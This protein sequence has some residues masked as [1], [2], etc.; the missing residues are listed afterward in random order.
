[1]LTHYFS[2]DK[3]NTKLLKRLL[4]EKIAYKCIALFN[5]THATKAF[6]VLVSKE[7]NKYTNYSYGLFRH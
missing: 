6:T 2:V 5:D 1:M 7:Q 3:L 4:Q